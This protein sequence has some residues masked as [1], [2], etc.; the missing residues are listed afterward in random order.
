MA[1]DASERINVTGY[2]QSASGTL[3][4][5]AWRYSGSGTLDPSV[6]ISHAGHA[7]TSVGETVGLGIAV[8]ATGR[9]L[10]CG[11]S[12]GQ[13]GLWGMTLWRYQADGSLDPTFNQGI[14]YLRDSNRQ[15]A[16]VSCAIDGSARI[17]VAGFAWSGVDWDMAV[18]RFSPSGDPDPTFGGDGFQSHHG[19]AGGNGEDVAIGLVLDAS[20]RAVATGYSTSGAGDQDLAIW[21]FTPAGALDTSF[22]GSGYAVHDNAGGAGGNDVGRAIAIDANNRIVVAGWS[23]NPAGGDDMA[24]WRFNSNGALDTTFSGDGYSTHNGAAGGSATDEG[25]AV[26]ID[27]AG[28]IVVAGAS[29]NAS[30]NLD[31]VIWRYLANGTLD[32]TLNGT[33]FAVLT[34]A[35]ASGI[36]DGARDLGIDSLGRVWA[37]GFRGNAVSSS[38]AA[39]WS[40][41]P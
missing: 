34:G 9:I 4:M 25:R 3:R 38:E 21:R 24:V 32:V 36:N 27:A 18:W 19:A 15:G 1:F 31:I 29:T 37:A 10:I 8:D 6:S 41:A 17:V 28:R 5:R 16:G 35:S 23:P 14:G 20:G 26:A 12:I 39:L 30:G 11:Y 13:D 2:S 22:N 40:L 33:G 7:G